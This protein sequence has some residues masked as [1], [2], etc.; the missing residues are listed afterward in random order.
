[1]VERDDVGDCLCFGVGDG[2]GVVIIGPGFDVVCVIVGSEG[3]DV[4]VGANV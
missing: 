4:V 2:I 3:G 1:M